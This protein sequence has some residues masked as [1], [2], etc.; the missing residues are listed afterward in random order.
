MK[1][2]SLNLSFCCEVQLCRLY[3]FNHMAADRINFGARL[4]IY[5]FVSRQRRHEYWF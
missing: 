4:R 2:E 3:Y 1:L 5:E